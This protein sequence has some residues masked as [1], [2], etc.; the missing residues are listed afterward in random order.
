MQNLSGETLNARDIGDRHLLQ[1]MLLTPMVYGAIFALQ[2]E[3]GGVQAML[4]LRRS[5]A[6]ALR[7]AGPGALL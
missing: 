7:R 1:N 3:A 4:H 2:P 5:V 6:N